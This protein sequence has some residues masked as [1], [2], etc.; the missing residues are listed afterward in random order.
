MDVLEELGLTGN[1]AKIFLALS[2]SEGLA[3]SEIATCTGFSRPYVYDALDRMQ[4]KQMVSFLKEEG[5]K[6]YTAAPPSFLRE[7]VRE[8]L[9]R[10]DQ[11]VGELE[12]VRPT[13]ELDVELHRGTGVF[14]V[15][16]K[17][18]LSTVK[19]QQEILIFGIDDEALI[20]EDENTLIQLQQY[21]A[22]IERKK[23]TERVIVR[24]GSRN[25][26]EATPSKYR[27]LPPETIGN[28][29]F[30]VY[31]DR[32]AIFFWGEPNHLVLIKNKEAA[33]SYRRQFQVL[34]DAARE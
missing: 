13:R 9:S 26:P 32:V 20:S 30:E 1:E 6:V 24:K 25:L 27:F 8:K 7:I 29:A 2:K 19:E 22:R 12:T 28:T 34:W 31:A 4:E 5:R 16:L 23:I 33:D 15:L 14:K 11:L 18:I 21:F 3:V 17:D 10:I